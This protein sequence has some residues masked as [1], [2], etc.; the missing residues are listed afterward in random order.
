MNDSFHI[1][2]FVN[3]TRENARALQLAHATINLLKEKNLQYSLHIDPWPKTLDNFSQAWIIGGDGTINWFVNQYPDANIPLAVFSGGSGNDF[4]WMIYGES[5]VKEQLEKILQAIP[6]KVDAGI[7]NGRIFMN[8][9]GIGFDGAIVHDLLGKKKLAGKASYLLSILK[10][11][12]SYREKEC[13]IQLS[14]ESIQQPCF[15][16]S[17][18]N[19]RRYGGGFMVAPRASLADGLLDINIVGRIPPLKRIKY[20]PVMEKGEHLELPFI[21]YRHA[22]HVIIQAHEKL[23]AHI[24]GEYIYEERFDI[25]ILPGRFSFLY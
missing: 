13:S 2:L 10:H 16:I 15:M 1:G 18:A 8:G 19:A 20:L 6:V 7:C 23:H 3:P 4:H 14:A 5:N 24:D 25:S 22:D 12:V 17:V 11:I 21:Q 9:V